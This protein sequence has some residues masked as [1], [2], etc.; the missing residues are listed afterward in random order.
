[1]ISVARI[2]RIMAAKTKRQTQNQVRR[3]VD[4]RSV[5][6]IRFIKEYG[7]LLG[8]EF[9]L[10]ADACC[11]TMAIAHVVQLGTTYVTLGH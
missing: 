4:A 9:A 2:P 5:R 7:L 8:T 3:F 10:L 6:A 11:L 1:M